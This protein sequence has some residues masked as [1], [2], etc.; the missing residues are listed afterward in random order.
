ML[1]AHAHEIVPVMATVTRK[2]V[3]HSHFSGLP[4]RDDLEI[5]E[6]VLPPIKDGG[7]FGHAF[8]V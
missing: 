1:G 2:Y 6:E 4:K 5:V 3:L 8:V 7:I